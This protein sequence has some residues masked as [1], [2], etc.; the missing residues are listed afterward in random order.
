MIRDGGSEGMVLFFLFGRNRSGDAGTSADGGN[1]GSD[2]G[3]DTRSDA[4]AGTGSAAGSGVNAGSRS[5]YRR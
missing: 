2:A 4:G 1:A 5:R 3:S